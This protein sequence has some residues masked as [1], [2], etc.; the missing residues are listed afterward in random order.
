MKAPS[1]VILDKQF[2]APLIKPRD[3]ASHKGSHGHAL[4]IA[5]SKG[6]MGAAVLSGKAC[7]RSGVGLLTINVPG[8]ERII[9]QTALPEAM[10]MIREEGG[11]INRFA[12]LGIGPALGTEDEYLQLLANIFEIYQAPLVLDAD[13]LT[14]LAPHKSYRAAI[15]AGSILTPHPGEFDRMFGSHRDQGERTIKAVQL[16]QQHPWVIVLKGHRTQIIL[17]GEIYMNTTGNAGLAKGGSG[18][19]LTG[20][21]L[22]LLA[23]GYI[24]FEAASIA[25]YL[26]GLAADFAV[27]DQSMESLLASDVIDSIGK[28][29]TSLRG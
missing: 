14:L 27:K 28:A 13:A 10:L 23:Q 4:L 17:N 18:D 3:P 1:P 6:R 9:V 24:P 8:E 12:A 11:D 29:F 5:G 19:V 2:I 16:S 15:P 25:V 21:I 26:H 22:A 7:L 20:I